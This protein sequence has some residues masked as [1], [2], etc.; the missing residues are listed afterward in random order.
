MTANATRT[1]QSNQMLLDWS[2]P[3]PPR[4]EERETRTEIERPRLLP[5]IPAESILQPE[6]PDLSSEALTFRN[7]DLSKYD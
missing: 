3:S 6:A 7:P 1:T 5:A 4:P 2:I